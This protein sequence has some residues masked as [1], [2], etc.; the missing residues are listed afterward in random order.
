MSCIAQ[1]STSIRRTRVPISISLVRS[2]FN[3]MNVYIAA[4]DLD[5]THEQRLITALKNHHLEFDRRLPQDQARRQS[6]AAA[7]VIFGNPPAAWL[8]QAPRLQWLQ[9]DTAGWESYK[10][11]NASRAGAP[12]RLTN[13]SGFFGRAV[14]E[15]ALAGILSYFR[16]LPRLIAA[17]A[18][19]KWI[20]A[21]ISPHV[22]HLHDQ[23]VTILGAGDI[24]QRLAALLRPFGGEI[25]FFA[26]RTAGAQLR[27]TADLDAALPTTQILINTLPHSEQTAGLLDQSRLARLE[28]GALFVNV[29][30]GSV[31]AETDLLAALG[32]G[33]LAGAVLDVTEVEPLPAESPLW[34]H[35]R[36]LLTQHTGGRFKGESDAK[37]D[38]FINNFSRFAS[39]ES[40]R[41]LIHL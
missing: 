4:T 8:P 3:E 25:R 35:P 28:P 21:E 7:D 15:T 14:S 38:F 37:V 31:V 11:L 32:D 18:Q 26:R 33:T 27:T 9:L 29:G 22:A 19:Q 20:R 10:G 30:R 17:Q 41:G 34:T 40:L 5:S 2:G 36:V 6:V 16:Q 39:G 24:G 1:Q 12:A 13:L 23:R